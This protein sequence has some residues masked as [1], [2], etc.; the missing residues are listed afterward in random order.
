[1]LLVMVDGMEFLEEKENKPHLSMSM[2]QGSTA[3]G[4]RAA[5]SPR[6][7]NGVVEAAEH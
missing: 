7:D 5:G 4:I 6:I 2:S 1:M 3:L